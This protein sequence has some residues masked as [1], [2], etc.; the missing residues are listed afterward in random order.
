M[1]PELMRGPLHVQPYSPARNVLP[2]EWRQELAHLATEGADGAA[3]PVRPGAA[4]RGEQPA[5]LPVPPALLE[6]VTAYTFLL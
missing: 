2:G 1:T 5:P 3:T 6:K 4:D